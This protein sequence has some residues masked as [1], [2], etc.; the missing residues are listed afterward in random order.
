[1]LRI[2]IREA[3][4]IPFSGNIFEGVVLHVRLRRGKAQAV[5]DCIGV[6]DGAPG[7]V[8]LDVAAAVDGFADE[9]DGAAKLG[10][11]VAQQV[12]GILE[13]VEDGGSIIAGSEALHGAGDIPSRGE[14]L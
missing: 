5:D 6:A 12:D 4:A 11:L 7:L 13:A 8:E 9:Q 1:M 3:S 14:V 2:W 10:R